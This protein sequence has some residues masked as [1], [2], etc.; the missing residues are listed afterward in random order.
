MGVDGI[1]SGGGRPIRDVGAGDPAGVRS[2]GVA[3]EGSAEIRSTSGPSASAELAR[4]ERG[5]IDLDRYLD[6]RVDDAVRH[7]EGRLPAAQIDFVRHSLR[8]QLAADPVLVELVRRATGAV[9]APTE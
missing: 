4:L 7:L 9:P 3:P 2:T 5:E 1:G 6:A 8:E